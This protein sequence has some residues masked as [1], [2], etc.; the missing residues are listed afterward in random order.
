MYTLYH[1][2]LSPFS[3]KIRV[4]L[5][6][7]SIEF[8]M[9][10]EKVWERRDGFIKLNPAG[11]V[12][13]LVDQEGNV[14]SDSQAISEYLEEIYPEPNLIGHTPIEKAE[15]RRLISWFD[16]KFQFEVT[17]HLLGEKI[18][19]KFLG[20]GEPSSKAVRVGK[21]NIHYHLDYIGWLYERRGWLAGDQISL[22]DITAASHLSCIDYLD[23][24]PWEEHSLAKDWYAK[25]KSRPSFRPILSDNIPGYSP[26][27]HYANLDF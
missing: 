18:M 21:M 4:L 8:D 6:E 11:K 12:P 7:K 14:F 15:V 17:R 20:L 27:E 2:W 13:V 19:K 16:E 24:V 22:A 23:D 25:V 9:V 3:R 1:L 10:V 26:P 5:H